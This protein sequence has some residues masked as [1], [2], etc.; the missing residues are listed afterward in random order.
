MGDSDIMCLFVYWDFIYYFMGC[1]KNTLS[2]VWYLCPKCLTSIQLQEDIRQMKI[3][4]HSIKELASTLQIDSPSP[5]CPKIAFLYLLQRGLRK[6]SELKKAKDT[7][8]RNAMHDNT[9]DPKPGGK[10][11]NW[12]NWQNWK[13]NYMLATVLG[14]IV[15]WLCK[16]MPLILENSHRTI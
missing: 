12:N 4:W 7:W 2:L 15:L 6:R 14:L 11:D 9:L 13:M 5:R 8:Y 3:E 1:T 16:R 10:N